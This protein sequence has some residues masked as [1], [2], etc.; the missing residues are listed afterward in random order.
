[1]GASISVN[2]GCKTFVVYLEPR[3]LYNYSSTAST[4]LTTFFW[5]FSAVAEC[6]SHIP[7]EITPTSSAEP[8][9]N[10]V[11]YCQGLKDIP[12]NITP[13]SVAV[14]LT[15]NLISSL[16]PNSFSSTPNCQSI[17]LSFNTIHSISNGAFNGLPYLM[18][19]FLSNN[20]IQHLEVGVFH[21][22]HSLHVID[23]KLNRLHILDPGLFQG[24]N[25]MLGLW[26][27]HNRIK[28]LRHGVVSGLQSLTMLDLAGN[29]L[30]QIHRGALAVLPSL[31]LLHLH[32]NHLRTF[33]QSVF[34]S[35]GD[36]DTT[37]LHERITPIHLTLFGNQLLCDSSVCWMKVSHSASHIWALHTYVPI[38]NDLRMHHDNITHQ[39]I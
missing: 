10:Y 29:S 17:D 8:G 28:E 38:E 27:N 30:M 11:Q 19:L 18:T 21:S 13:S 1:M 34:L 20:R 23:L 33:Q 5:N 7:Q 15:G 16:P 3:T 26:L 4:E 2:R 6:A 22:L 36:Y 14:L 24:L 12:Q 32:L 31:N 39:R 9:G 25:S 37:Q 35:P